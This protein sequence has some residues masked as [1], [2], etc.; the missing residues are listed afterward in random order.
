M[1]PTLEKE[2]DM[3]KNKTLASWLHFAKHLLISTVTG[4]FL[5]PFLRS[6]PE[7]VH[8]FFRNLADWQRCFFIFCVSSLVFKIAFN[9]FS[10]SFND[11]KA[12]RKHPPTWLAWCGSLAITCLLD[13]TLG[14]SPESYK[15]SINDWIAYCLLPWIVI[16]Y[17]HC[18]LET[19]KT[20][21]FKTNKVNALLNTESVEDNLKAWLEYEEPS[22]ID[23]FD[24]FLIAKKIHSS[25]QKG[26]RSIG[27]CG[28]FGSGKSTVIQQLISIFENEQE[29]SETKTIISTN[30][31]W[32]FESSSSSI[33][34]IME[35]VI[36][37]ADGY[38]DTYYVQS[39]P[40][41][42]V[43]YMSS[44]AHWF[45][46][47][48]EPIF[49]SNNPSE[50]FERLSGLLETRK[51]KILL[52]VEDL[53]RNNGRDFDA[54]EIEGFLQQIK[55]YPNICIVISGDATRERNIS[56]SKLCDR[57]EYLSAP[58]TSET[59]SLIHCFFRF[60]SQEMAGKYTPLR[61]EL[62]YKWDEIG[63]FNHEQG[64]KIGLAEAVVRLARTPRLIKHVLR[65]TYDDWEIMYGEVSIDDLMITN[66]LRISSPTCFQFLIDRWSDLCEAPGPADQRRRES[67]AKDWEKLTQISEWDSIAAERLVIEILPTFYC[68]IGMS[69][70]AIRPA[71][72][73]QGLTKERYW[74]RVVKRELTRDDVSDQKV[75]R[76]FKDWVGNQSGDSEV[77]C[78]LADGD[79][80]YFETFK[81]V[82]LFFLN[83]NRKYLLSFASDLLKRIRIV[84]GASSGTFWG[85]ESLD[86]VLGEFR[87]DSLY[88][89]WLKEEIEKSSGTSLTLLN[90]IFHLYASPKNPDQRLATE[91]YK[92]LRASI[93]SIFQHKDISE[94]DFFWILHEDDPMS[95]CDFVFPPDED[96]DFS[97][98]SMRR[99]SWLSDLLVR[100]LESK[101]KDI[102][103]QVSQL[104]SKRN[105]DRIP[106]EPRTCDMDIC[107]SLFENDVSNLPRLLK[108]CIAGHMSRVETTFVLS[109]AESIESQLPTTR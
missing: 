100:G 80:R 92:E 6:N 88:K 52:I 81:D 58:S 83:E 68:W 41:E 86:I 105:Q 44:E 57:I 9:I 72:L 14:L 34:Q 66:L 56:F 25:I 3:K 60:C 28:S 19:G 77:V 16:G 27:V 79:R 73:P 55:Q 94:L 21:E 70:K 18:V 13:L 101:R 33:R 107:S 2:N 99:W 106:K 67:V 22:T 78:R 74:R 7:Q 30:S 46:K 39:L 61:S 8:D 89:D 102:A 31:C 35:S 5:L 53:D 40:S 64:H 12:I 23:L 96:I 87:F 71:D 97:V 36:A 54:Q 43:K 65:Q 20:E 17:V 59:R 108:E 1:N 76:D 24:T 63:W 50:Q 95:I 69:A 104:L 48:A 98:D 32:G 42:Y 109:I 103:I 37:K 29:F 10:P 15:S 93:I 38:I 84:H 75:I 91:D 85:L 47:L 90:K 26:T 11:L 51:V 45:E 82:S 62:H 49:G 4:I